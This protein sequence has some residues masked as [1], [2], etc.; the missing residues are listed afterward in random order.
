[1]PTSQQ[2][3]S[4]GA[5]LVVGG[6][7]YIG[8]HMTRLLCES[9]YRVLVLDNLQ[10]GYRDAVSDKAEFI[11]GDMADTALLSHV[12][13]HNQIACVMHLASDIQVGE[14]VINP[15]KYYHN[16]VLK[17]LELLEQMVEHEVEQF[18]FSSSAAIFGNPEYSPIDEQHP[19]A[20]LSPYGHSK[21]MIEQVLADYE[22]AY[23]LR[24]VSLR[25]FN[26]AGAHPD[27]TLGERH[28]PET[29]LIPLVLQAAS[30]RRDAITVFGNDYPTPDG[31]C[32]RD[33]IHVMDLC[34]AH[35]QA[36][37]YLADGGTS[38]A[39]NLGNGSGFSV[40]Q[41]IECASGVTGVDIPVVYAERRE[42][43][44]AI[45]VADSNM[46]SNVLG[47]QPKYNQLEVILLHAW[48]WEQ[49]SDSWAVG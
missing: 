11:Y 31:T 19:K 8:S 18:V 25:Y 46:A 40:N 47:W 39:L 43:D 34:Q 44:P 41:V 30:N 27:G 12:F 17:T 36:V 23:G 29:H 21:L 20:P 2:Q 35:L 48:Q 37:E 3:E 9:G 22:T 32:V 33:Y 45:L 15:L 13:S 4:S 5:I 38:I 10:A 24:S 42:G 7:G 26:A 28:L 49:Q 14:S 6:A 1:M 16:N